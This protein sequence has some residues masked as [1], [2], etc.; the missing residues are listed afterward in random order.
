MLANYVHTL[1]ITVSKADISSLVAV[2]IERLFT[3]WKLCD[4]THRVVIRTS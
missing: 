3:M 4:W 1:T 2:C